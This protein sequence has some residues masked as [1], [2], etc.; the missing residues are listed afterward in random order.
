MKEYVIVTDST[1]DLDKEQIKKLGIKVL[2]LGFTLDRD[3][4][5]ESENFDAKKFYDLM[6]EGVI[7]TTTQINITTFED[8]FSSYLDQGLDVLYISFSSQLS[9]TFASASIAARE[10][11]NKYP[12]R[13]VIVK[14]SLSACMGEGLLVYYAVLK[15][16][17][18]LEIE[19]LSSWI[20]ENKLNICHLFTVDDLH[21]LKRGGRISAASA[22]FGSMLNVK[23]ILHVSNEGKLIPID[24]VRGR[25]ASLLNIVEK[26]KKLYDD[27]SDRTV[28]IAHADCLEDAIFV[29]NKIEESMKVKE[30]V[31]N[32]IGP[33]IGAHA[34]PGTLA[35][36]FRGNKR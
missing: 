17:E 34:G 19:E 2:P 15:K 21:F 24:K 32:Y 35:V 22:M 3:V 12:E 6:R 4:K 11:K 16:Q 13:K 10:L 29:K 5:L 27:T 33:V 28:F 36:F 7:A 23:P 30:V 31:I 25:K 18:G 26:M 9:N 20:D 14:D 8:V 1:C